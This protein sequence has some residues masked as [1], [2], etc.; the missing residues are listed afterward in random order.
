M[1]NL[2]DTL[3]LFTFP[4]IH[5]GEWFSY[6]LSFKQIA[7]KK[8]RQTYTHGLFILAYFYVMRYEFNSK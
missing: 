8:V 7:C 6:I 5:K 2:K 3:S 1:Y 4:G